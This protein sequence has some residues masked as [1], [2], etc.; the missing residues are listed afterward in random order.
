[1]SVRVYGAGG[2]IRNQRSEVRGVSS[3][4]L[5]GIFFSAFLGVES[6]LRPSFGLCYSM[7]QGR[8][9]QT[10]QA[11][12]EHC[13]GGFSLSTFMIEKIRSY[14]GASGSLFSV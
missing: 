4:N 8:R 10:T 13:L 5:G 1:M 6:L 14:I 12:L 3:L 2:R 7:A 11:I 9:S